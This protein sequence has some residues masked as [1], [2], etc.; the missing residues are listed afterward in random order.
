MDVVEPSQVEDV[1]ELDGVAHVRFGQVVDQ[2]GRRGH[3]PED[4]SYL[5]AIIRT[6]MQFDDQTQFDGLLPQSPHPRIVERVEV[7]RLAPVR[8][9]PGGDD[10]GLTGHQVCQPARRIRVTRIEEGRA[11]KAVGVAFQ[12]VED[13]AMVV[14]VGLGMH[15]DGAVD[16]CRRHPIDVALQGVFEIPHGGLVRRPRVERVALLI[17]VEDVRVPL[18]DHDGPP[19]SDRGVR[20]VVDRT[21]STRR[22]GFDILTVASSPDPSAR[23]KVLRLT[24]A[25][26]H[27]DL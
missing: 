24:L 4:R 18:D 14:A 20:T 10:P 6:D 19:P 12:T 5:R 23:P 1:G 8:V 7:H 16:A 27:E 25:S 15:E 26:S 21:P 22:A 13:E 11:Q 9:E 3:V 17:G 2:H